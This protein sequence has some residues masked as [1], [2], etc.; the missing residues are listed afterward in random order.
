MNPSASNPYPVTVKQAPVPGPT[1]LAFGQAVVQH[2]RMV[3]LTF[4]LTVAVVTAMALARGKAFTA[5]STFAPET[6]SQMGR[7]AGLAAQFGFN[8]EGAPGSESIFFYAEVIKSRALLRAL[9]T[10]TF[11]S[12]GLQERVGKANAPLYEL[13][14]V[15]G[16]TP[17]LKT[18]A[19]VDRLRREVTVRTDMKSNTVTV[20]TRAPT[21]PLAIAMNRRLIE[22]LND[23]NV[24]KRRSAASNERQF[25]SRQLEQDH[26]ELLAAERKL[27]QFYEQNRQYSNSPQLRIREAQLQR[28]LDLRQQVYS[29]ISEAHEQARINEVRSTPVITL[30]DP[31]DGSARPT[32]RLL[33]SIVVGILLAS[34]LSLGLV[35]VLEYAR[36]EREEHPMQY[37]A[38]RSALGELRLFRRQVAN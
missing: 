8:L 5:D 26:R 22:L 16:K 2:R 30:V 17:A 11:P 25:T 34:V 27:Q 12:G 19:A 24:T 38:F 3:L 21:G 32:N 1:L 18:A 10:T 23:Y 31:A 37:R 35:V 33:P 15:E 20:I 36:R 29:S 13:L 6:Q 4:F 28:E 9:A 7:A 14:D